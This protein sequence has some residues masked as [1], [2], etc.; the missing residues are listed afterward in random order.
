MRR[1]PTTCTHRPE[2]EM[3][4]RPRDIDRTCHVDS[5]PTTPI[6]PSGSRVCFNCDSIELVC[7]ILL[8]RWECVV[9]K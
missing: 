1:P 5:R 8:L 6:F 9:L 3:S 7:S 2:N 4:F